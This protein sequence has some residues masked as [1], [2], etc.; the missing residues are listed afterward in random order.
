MDVHHRLAG[1]FPD[2]NADVVSRR[3][4]RT[5]DSLSRGS[6]KLQNVGDLRVREIE[7]VRDVATRD[8]QAVAWRNGVSVENDE[9]VI[10]GLK[11]TLGRHRAE[12]AGV[13][14]RCAHS[15]R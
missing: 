5:I 1:V 6:D 12:W 13:R 2:V 10:V 11:H 3:L 7:D 9:G 14:V 15:T 4:K 8:D